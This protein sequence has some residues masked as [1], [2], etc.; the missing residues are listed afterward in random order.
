MDCFFLAHH[1]GRPL[2]EIRAMTIEELTMWR[3]Y[4]ILTAPKKE[5]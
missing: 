4:F 2:R 5:E 3:A 1:L